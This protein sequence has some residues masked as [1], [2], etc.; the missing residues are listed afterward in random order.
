MRSFQALIE[1][2][3]LIWLR[4]GHKVR[5]EFDLFAYTLF[6]DEIFAPLYD[7]KEVDFGNLTT[8][9]RG[10]YKQV[11]IEDLLSELPRSVDYSKVPD[12]FREPGERIERVLM[13]LHSLLA[14]AKK[15]GYNLIASPKH[16]DGFINFCLSVEP[17]FLPTLKHSFLVNDICR[18]IFFE[19]LQCADARTEKAFA[20]FDAFKKDFQSGVIEFADKFS[21]SYC[22]NEEQTKYIKQKIAEEE[23]RVL[24]YLQPESL[25][26]LLN[27][28]LVDL[29]T[30][31]GET[32]IGMALLLPVPLGLFVDVCKQ[33]Y[34]HS[35]FKSENLNFA[36]S[37]VVL[38]QLF[39][40]RKPEAPSK[41]EVCAITESEIDS[42]PKGDKRI[43]EIIFGT[44]CELHMIACLDIRKKYSLMGKD[45]LVAMKRF[46]LEDIFREPH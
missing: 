2:S 30:E 8:Y 27:I 4:A 26:K 43:E 15:K 18:Y 16:Y 28:S 24:G 40:I 21:G 14:F 5:G 11:S 13:V 19:C 45:L 9:F 17:E 41:C 44:R 25:K 29:A 39:N 33:L 20:F 10:I 6:Y 38:K 37:I 46:R 7:P 22:L 12:P 1:P 3:H 32:A 36:L 31:A 35:K 42:I 34:K 23:R